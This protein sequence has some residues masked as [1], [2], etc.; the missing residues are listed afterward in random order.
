[1]FCNAFQNNVIVYNIYKN[2]FGYLDDVTRLAGASL[3]PVVGYVI[4]K[5]P[6][7]SLLHPHEADLA[8]HLHMVM[9]RDAQ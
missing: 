3:H 8:I 2:I 1:M 6:L 9:L 7:Q 4:A 5:N